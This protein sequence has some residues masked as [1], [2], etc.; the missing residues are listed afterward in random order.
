MFL[1]AN[2]KRRTKI[3]WPPALFHP[4]RRA[5]AI[6]MTPHASEGLYENDIYFTS[7]SLVVSFFRYDYHK[8]L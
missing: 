8:Q 3:V 5:P 7:S 2:P 6:I 4:T 1:F